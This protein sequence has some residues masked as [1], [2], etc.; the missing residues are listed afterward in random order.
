MFRNTSPRNDRSSIS[1]RAVSAPFKLLVAIIEFFFDK[2]I[3]DPVVATGTVVGSEAP[4]SCQQSTVVCPARIA[5]CCCLFVVIIIIGFNSNVGQKTRSPSDLIRIP[6]A[7]KKIVA[8]T[9]AIVVD[10]IVMV[11][12]MVLIVVSGGVR[13]VWG[14]S[15]STV[16]VINAASIAG[17][18][19]INIID[20]I[21]EVGD[22]SVG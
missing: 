22:D 19:V 15:D 7:V 12:V 3:V 21:V 20:G 11:H 18:V 10:V 2:F 8:A 9:I 4:R 6:S 5:T 1:S 16:L 13:N 17:N 14:R